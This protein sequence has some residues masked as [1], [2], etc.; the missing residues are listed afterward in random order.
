MGSEGGHLQVGLYC[1]MAG[2]GVRVRHT[3]VP[4]LSTLQ[5][6]DP[7]K[8]GNKAL[9]TKKTNDPI[10]FW[11]PPLTGWQAGTLL[12]PT[13]AELPPGTRKSLPPPSFSLTLC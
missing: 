1:Q 11:L 3:L 4:L 9:F 2:D 8:T 10:P 5:V 6:G 12:V 7:L 13:C